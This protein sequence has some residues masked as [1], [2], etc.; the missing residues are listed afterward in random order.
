MIEY[1][2]EQKEVYELEWC[3]E[4]KYKK[5]ILDRINNFEF[6]NNWTPKQVVDYI[7]YRIDRK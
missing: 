1:D 2:M 5:E 3:L 6:P 4:S 7:T